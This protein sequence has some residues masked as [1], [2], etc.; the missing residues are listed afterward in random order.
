[1]SSKVVVVVFPSSDLLTNALDHISNLRDVAVRR[2]AIVA[3]AASGELVILD[4]KIS[5]NDGGFVGGVIGGVLGALLIW[6]QGA[7]ALSGIDLV[8][9]LL[10]GFILGVLIGS[11][12]AWFL[13]DRFG[14][15]KKPNRFTSLVPQLQAGRPALILEIKPDDVMHNLLVNELNQ[16]QAEFVSP[17]Q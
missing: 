12:V 3:K 14:I 9:M 16:F 10:I 15:N 11:P 8:I 7:F 13:A 17:N 6:E 2:A 1:M 4:D 5:A